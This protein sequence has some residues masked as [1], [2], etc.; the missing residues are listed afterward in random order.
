MNDTANE[1]K[2]MKEKSTAEAVKE[3]TIFMDA[4]VKELIAKPDIQAAIRRYV[5]VPKDV[6][7]KKVGNASKDHH[8]QKIEFMYGETIE[9]AVHGKATIY[10][11]KHVQFLNPENAINKRHRIVE[12]ELALEANMVGGNFGGYSATGLKLVIK[13][14]EEIK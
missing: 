7:I 14:L 6:I 9:D 2:I 10:D 3:K 11:E 8:T 1:T 12:Y 13:K 4:K 5:S